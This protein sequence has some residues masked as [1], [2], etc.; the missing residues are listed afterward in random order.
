[1][2][3]DIVN[4]LSSDS[5]SKLGTASGSALTPQQNLELDDLIEAFESAWSSDESKRL[6][7][8]TIVDRA[9]PELRSSLFAELVA[10][11]CELRTNLG[12]V[13][14]THLTLPTTPYV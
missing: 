11:E 9:D 6:S 3:H 5:G 12:A 2:S 13:S 14:Y 8:V 1:M 10:V 7:I 4:D